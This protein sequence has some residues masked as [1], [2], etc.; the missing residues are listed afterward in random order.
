MTPKQEAKDLVDSFRM[1]LRANLMDDREADEDGKQCA[2]ICENNT[3]KRIRSLKISLET[4]AECNKY[5]EQVKQE[6]EKL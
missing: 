6:I 1:Y 5:S 3:I 4:I 2:L